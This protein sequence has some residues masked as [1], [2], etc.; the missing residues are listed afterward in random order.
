MANNAITRQG[1]R[2]LNPINV[3]DPETKNNFELIDGNFKTIF[4]KMNTN[5][6]FQGQTVGLAGVVSPSTTAVFPP[7]FTVTAQVSGTRPVAVGLIPAGIE[8]FNLPGT[9]PTGGNIEL[10]TIALGAIGVLTNFYFLAD[11][12]SFWGTSKGFA[13]P[14]LA[15]LEQ[16]HSYISPSELL[17]IHIPPQPG[18]V[19]YSL[20]FVNILP[21]QLTIFNQLALFAVEIF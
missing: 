11:G 5:R 9:G 7:E 8:A 13:G 10:Q 3:K 2:K 1:Q 20:A 4:S 21:N 14:V 16:Y 19:K 6:Y 15:A 18:Q 17:G 12:V